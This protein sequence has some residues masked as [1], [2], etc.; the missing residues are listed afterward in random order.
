MNQIQPYAARAPMMV[1]VGNHERNWRGH[2]SPIRALA[3]EQKPRAN[4]DG[5]M[6]W[7]GIN[8][9]SS[10]GEC[11]IPTETRFAMPGWPWGIHDAG[12][13][14]RVDRPNA[15]YDDEPWYLY[16]YGPVFFYM[17][18]TEHDVAPG[19]RQHEHFAQTLAGVD[20][21]QT[22]WVVVTGHR[23]MYIDSTDNSLPDG[24]Q[25]IAQ[26]MRDSLE[27]LLLDHQV[28]LAIWGHNHNYQRSCRVF[29]TTCQGS[30]SDQKVHAAHFLQPQ[31]L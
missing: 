6:D 31:C 10:G 12:K 8:S 28:D 4:P 3:Q 7:G 19:S 17:L 26:W 25:P 27:Q 2:S 9:S 11:G 29:N 20:R 1:Q 21:V 14:G 5:L 24:D 18:S 15:R 23:M 16:T 13:W 22:P 30:S